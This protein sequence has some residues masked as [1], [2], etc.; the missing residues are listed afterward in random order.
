M[1]SG[2]G[3]GG[4]R[5]KHIKVAGNWTSV[6]SFGWDHYHCL[7][8]RTAGA[9]TGTLRWNYRTKTKRYILVSGLCYCMAVQ[10]AHAVWANTAQYSWHTAGRTEHNSINLRNQ[11]QNDIH[12]LKSD[13]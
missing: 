7:A 1:R 13:K 3:V 11:E 4:G 12:T 2:G 8:A 6:M 9:L 5:S 10:P